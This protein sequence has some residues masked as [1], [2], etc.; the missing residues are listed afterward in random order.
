M[1]F[2]LFVIHSSTTG[3]FSPLTTASILFPACESKEEK[4]KPS[5]D[6]G[7]PEIP[8]LIFFSSSGCESSGADA[9]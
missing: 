7:N 6:R 3:F 2:E 8:L 9:T 5:L 4:E 1:E